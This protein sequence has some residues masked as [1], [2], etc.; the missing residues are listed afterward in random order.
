[1]IL[2]VTVYFENFHSQNSQTF[3]FVHLM[4]W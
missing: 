4:S 2:H 1:M 3:G